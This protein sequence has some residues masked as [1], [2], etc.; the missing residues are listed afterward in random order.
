L[1]G[2]TTEELRK[3]VHIALNVQ[4]IERDPRSG[5]DLMARKTGLGGGFG[6]RYG[7]LVAPV[8]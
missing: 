5:K 4:R 3:I 6:A 1:S 8:H 2:F 7:T